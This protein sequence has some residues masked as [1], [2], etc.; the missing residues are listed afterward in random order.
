MRPKTPEITLSDPFFDAIVP[1]HEGSLQIEKTHWVSRD[2]SFKSI[3]QGK[4]SAKPAECF[5][6]CLADER[7]PY[8]KQSLEDDTSKNQQAITILQNQKNNLG[9]QGQEI[10]DRLTSLYDTGVYL[11]IFPVSGELQTHIFELKKMFIS[12]AGGALG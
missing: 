8:S 3:V 10:L 12:L 4:F 1:V 9:R 5:Q 7:N 6:D 2:T 11:D